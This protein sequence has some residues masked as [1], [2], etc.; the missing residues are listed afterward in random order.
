MSRTIEQAST[1]LPTR[2]VLPPDARAPAAARRAVTVLTYGLP[3]RLAQRVR[4]VASELVTNSLRHAVASDPTPTMTVHLQS[5]RVMLTVHD[6]GS[7]FDFD[8]GECNGGPD[9]GWGLRLVGSL[10][11]RW[12]IER[13][14]GTRVVCEF[15]R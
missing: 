1:R 14:H 11:D 3:A 15:D 8:S 5:D 12:R 13:E 10:V 9:G 6:R 2:V 4:L 7:R